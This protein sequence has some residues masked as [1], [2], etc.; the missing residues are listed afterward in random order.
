MQT[1]TQ[2]IG[3]RTPARVIPAIDNFTLI[4]QFLLEALPFSPSR[5]G[6]VDRLILSNG[7]LAASLSERHRWVT[8]VSRL[9]HLFTHRN[10]IRYP[11]H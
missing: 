1:T 2:Q 6:A 11:G 7:L 4:L 10:G 5:C 8:G 9:C 3:M